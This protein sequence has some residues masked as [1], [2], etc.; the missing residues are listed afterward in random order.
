MVSTAGGF[1]GLGLL[2]ARWAVAE[3]AAKLT[4]LDTS[5]RRPAHGSIADLQASGCSTQ[6]AIIAADVAQAE[7]IQ[8]AS[9][10]KVDGVLHAA[11]VLRD[12]LLSKQTASS[13]R[14]VLAGKVSFNMR[15]P[16]F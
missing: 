1:G 10:S 14:V 4:L 5:A 8:L 15:K 6:V 9:L 3:K 13:F 16:D 2:F 12:A 11:G 7:D